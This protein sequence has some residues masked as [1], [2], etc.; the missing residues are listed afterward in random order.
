MP[1]PVAHAFIGAAT[2]EVMLPRET[3]HRLYMV[4]AAGAL[5]VAPDLDF[6][7]VWVLGLD[8]D[9]HRGF[10]HSLLMA[11]LLGGTALAWW[12]RTRWREA[13]AFGLALASH[14]LLDALTTVQGRGVQLFWPLWMERFRL[15]VVDLWEMQPGWLAA[16]ELGRALHVSVLELLLLGPVVL[17]LFCIRRYAG[18]RRLRP[19]SEA[20]HF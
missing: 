9:W 16:G 19:P 1:L 11:A 6:I 18:R 5:A 17:G 20:T 4:L 2:A 15:G 3:R 7:L 8:R 14:G 12:G 13:A 10:S